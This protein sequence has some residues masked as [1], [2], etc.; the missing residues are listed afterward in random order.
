MDYKMRDTDFVPK[1]EV[2]ESFLSDSEIFEIEKAFREYTD[3][4]I[5][6]EFMGKKMSDAHA[7]PG[8]GVQE[9]STAR[10]HYWYPG[11]SIKSWLHEMMNEKIRELYG[12]HIKCS[13]WHILN[14]YKPYQI[15]SDSYD[16]DD[17]KAT[18]LHQDD[19]NYAWTYLIPLED[20]PDASTIV[21]NETSNFSKV[22]KK[23]AAKTGAK[24]Q[25]SITDEEYENLFT[26][27]LRD[28]VDLFS[29][30][31]VFPWKKGDLLS[32]GRHAFHCSS[33]FPAKGVLQKR[34]LIG[35]SYVE[36]NKLLG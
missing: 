30:D 19:A 31:T 27:E 23:W 4:D 2:V 17:H 13:N 24:P 18:A 1:A 21:F 22:P 9:M 36:G 15:H 11:E 32:M 25:Y 34:A 20:Y 12:P 16:E 5:Q 3:L 35:W 8:K 28:N 33:N 10:S 7:G 14:A 29:I 26:H 6:I